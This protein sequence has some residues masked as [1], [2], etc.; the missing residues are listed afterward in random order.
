MSYGR[1]YEDFTP[2]EVISHDLTKTILESDNNI[3][4]LLTMNHH[5]VHSD[6]EYAKSHQHGQI[7]VVGTLVFS[8]AVGI[9]V[10]DISGHAVA[11]LEY[12]NVKHT[13]PVF[14]NDTIH[15]ITEILS[16]RDSRKKPD[17]GIVHVKSR[18]FNQ[19]DCEV[20]SFERKVLV[21]KKG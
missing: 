2:G 6:I 11:N 15:V 8:L 3:F 19:K 10:Q 7:L 20:L 1:F 13:A 5:P 16:K 4:C 18:V 21:F 12:N 17:R 9:T 14:I